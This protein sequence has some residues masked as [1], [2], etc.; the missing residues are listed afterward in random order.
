MNENR[1]KHLHKFWNPFIIWFP[2]VNLLVSIQT[3]VHSHTET[4]TNTWTIWTLSIHI[5]EHN[6][7]E[8]H[9][10]HACIQSGGKYNS[11]MK[12]KGIYK[13]FD[14]LV[15]EQWIFELPT[16]CLVRIRINAFP[17]I[18]IFDGFLSMK[19]FF[20]PTFISS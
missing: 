18:I 19:C 5:P 6:S 8:L 13:A 17:F 7:T 16:V 11:R 14:E 2:L 1:T 12:W 15:N 9:T 20:F 4:C 10:N 3:F